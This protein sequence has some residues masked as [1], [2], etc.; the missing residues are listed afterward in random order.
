[1]LFSFPLSIAYLRRFDKN[2]TSDQV[3]LDLFFPSILRY[4][5]KSVIQQFSYSTNRPYIIALVMIICRSQ[6]N[7][8][9]SSQSTPVSRVCN[10]QKSVFINF[11]RIRSRKLLDQILLVSADGKHENQA[12]TPLTLHKEQGHSKLWTKN[13][14]RFQT[15]QKYPWMAT[16]L[17]TR[18]RAAKSKIPVPNSQ[19]RNR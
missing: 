5:R 18:M 11:K 15:N 17:K 12:I 4:E 2:D 16:I 1:M 3:T 6:P 13:W 8:Y 14:L 9:I 7:S 19:Y 10:M